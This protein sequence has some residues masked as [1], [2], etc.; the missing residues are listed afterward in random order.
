VRALVTGAGGFLGSHLVEELLA[1]DSQVRALVRPS[2]QL[3]AG[4][5]GRGVERAPVDLRRPGD[6]LETALADADV[7]FHLAATT[8]GTWRSMFDTT[9]AAT[10]GLLDAMRASGWRGRLVHVSSFSVYGL[11]QVRARSLVDESTPLEPDPGRRDDYAWTKWLQERLVR[12]LRDEGGVEVAIVRPGVIYGP[13]RAFQH[14]LGRE[15]GPNVLLLYGGLITMRLTYVENTASL[16]AECGENPRAAGEVFN[17]IDPRP[18]RQLQYARRWRDADRAN[19]RVVPF[20]LFALRALGTGLARAAEATDGAVSPPSFL[21]PYK[22][23]PA[24]GDFRYDTAKATRVLGWR[25]PVSR[26]RA[27][28]LTFAEAGP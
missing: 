19:R 1:R 18:L 16:L 28:E 11:N 2:R 12:E 10:Q 13:G 20:P 21:D 22:L 9:V 17:A 15:L 25:P 3:P 5:E 26:E 24:Y 8:A 6:R 4:W 7:V 27:L 23:K 14:Q